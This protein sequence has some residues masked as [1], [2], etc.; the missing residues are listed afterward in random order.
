[1]R[2]DVNRMLRWSRRLSFVPRW[3]VVPTLHK[4]NVAEHTFHVAQLCRWLLARHASGGDGKFVLEVL[5]DA[6]DHD[7]KEAAEGDIPSPRKTRPEPFS[8][9]EVILKC[10]DLLEALAFL[11]EERNFGGL[12]WVAPIWEDVYSKFH[13]AWLLFEYI[14]TKKPL[15]SDIVKFT[16]CEVNGTN[17]KHHPGLE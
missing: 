9:K 14:D 2:T 3:V 16:L 5:E 13:E 7:E 17:N 12:H 1:M 6:L 10:A 4:Q 15:T 11:Q 8:Q